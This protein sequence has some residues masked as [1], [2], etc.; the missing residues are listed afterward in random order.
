MLM[1]IAITDNDLKEQIVKKYSSTYDILEINSKDALMCIQKEYENSIVIISQDLLGKVN[2]ET[3]IKYI[4]S[5]N[6]ETQIIPLVNKLENSLKELLFS[7]EIF[8]IIETNKATLEEIMECINNPKLVIYKSETN[9]NKTNVIA[10]TGAKNSGKTI[11]AILLSRK[12]AKECKT[13]K[14]V[15]VDIDFLSPSIYLYLNGAKNYSMQDYIKDVQENKIKGRENYETIDNKLKNL[16]YILN[17]TP[18]NI[19][20]DNIIER[21]IENLKQNYDYIILDTSY[22]YMNKLYKSRY[23]II[24]VILDNIKGIRDYMQDTMCFS[25]EQ[26]NKTC[27]LFNMKKRG[28]KRGK[29]VINGSVKISYLSTLFNI[30]NFKLY[31]E[32]FNKILKKIGII[33]FEKLKRKI[34]IKLMQGDGSYE[35]Q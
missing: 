2:F 12:I 10:I 21:L 32:D 13:K 5:I 22:Y 4:K 14:V 8:N 35:K 24:H 9:V 19:P 20:E 18:M 17:S 25:N 3:V 30:F 29:I 1:I 33:R 23:R 34:I 15:L 31:R 16:K 11:V 6:I 28:N 26:I 7:K 27:V